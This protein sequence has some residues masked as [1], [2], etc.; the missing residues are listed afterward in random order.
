MVEPRSALDDST[1]TLIW[2]VIG[3]TCDFPLLKLFSSKQS[4]LP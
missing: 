2:D 3:H 1:L 4:G